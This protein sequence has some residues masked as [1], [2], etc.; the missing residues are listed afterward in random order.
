[1]MNHRRTILSAVLVI[2]IAIAAMFAQDRPGQVKW[3]PAPDSLDSLIR[4]KDNART[5]LTVAATSSDTTFTVG[6]AAAFPASGFFVIGGRETASYTDHTN[7]TF[8]GVLRGL[9]GTPAVAHTKTET[10]EQ[11][12]LAVDHNTLAS[13]LLAIE[14]KIGSGA[15]NPTSGKFLKGGI[16]SGTSSWGIITAE[17]LTGALGATPVTSASPTFTGKVTMGSTTQK[18]VVDPAAGDSSNTGSPS[19]FL[20]PT[21]SYTDSTHFHSVAMMIRP[22]LPLGTTTGAQ[23]MFWSPFNVVFGTST[24]RIAAA[25]K[26]NPNGYVVNIFSAQPASNMSE[27][28]EGFAATLNGTGGAPIYGSAITI[29]TSVVSAN[30]IGHNL[31]ISKSVAGGTQ[32]GFFSSSGGPLVAT[33]AY[34]AVGKWDTGFDASGITNATSAIRIPN[35]LA[36]VGR[37]FANTQ[38]IQ[39]IRVTTA[40]EIEF[41]NNTQINTA[42]PY[43]RLG[44]VNTGWLTQVVDSDHRLR[45]NKNDVGEA[46]SFDSGLGFVMGTAAQ[47]TNATTGFF[48]LAGMAGAPLGTP[49][50]HTGR[51]PLTIDTVN[52]RL[53]GYYGGSWQNL[54]A[55]GG[56][57]GSITAIDTGNGLQ[58]GVIV[59]S[60][61]IDLRL[62]SGGGLSKT[63]GGGSNELGIAAGGVTNAMLAGSIADAK[64]S[65][66]VVLKN[67]ANVLTTVNTFQRD[68]IGVTLAEGIALRNATDATAL[69]PTQMAPSIGFFG[70]IWDLD[71]EESHQAAAKLTWEPFLAPDNARRG[72]LI[73]QSNQDGGTFAVPTMYFA[74]DGT[75]TVRHA[76]EVNPSGP[77]ATGV[78]TTIVNPGT[79]VMSGGGTELGQYGASGIILNASTGGLQGL[80]FHVYQPTSAGQRDSLSMLLGGSSFDTTGHDIEWKLF[81][82]VTS[83]AGASTLTIQSRIDGASFVTKL[84]I[85]DSGNV[86]VPGLPVFAN[87]AAAVTGGLAV[88]T[89]YRTGADPDV[90]C[91]TH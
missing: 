73:L 16:A 78:A 60:G 18:V 9:E 83:N 57:G 26:G 40:D 20:E 81:T 65:S 76:F 43:A 80:A 17:D 29:E 31:N 36:I 49:T 46:A 24:N 58:G 53:M 33:A 11:R 13:L 75:L 38:D 55:T 48:Y 41:G 4:V 79:I 69:A 23:G 21:F 25:T 87:N 52:G 27:A 6:S 66:N 42:N 77:D 64:L 74:D 14:G 63:L 50:A 82:D 91:V 61:T 7:T 47:A 15:S 45:F 84:S 51:V 2:L 62:N 39:M 56:G 89:F 59:A 30:A 32:Y 3:P 35:N 70:S 72:R 54:S 67:A 71:R 10:V 1:M 34:A 44:P 8:T 90:V 86:I 22:Q 37:N 88:G 28:I 68:N 5:T 85:T 19:L 12:I